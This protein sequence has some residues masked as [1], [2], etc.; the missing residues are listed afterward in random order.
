MRW[1]NFF[2]LDDA[3]FNA[4]SPRADVGTLRRELLLRTVVALEGGPAPPDLQGRLVHV[5][6]G[7]GHGGG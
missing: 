1:W 4:E 3:T 7:G 5:P 2:F 6:E